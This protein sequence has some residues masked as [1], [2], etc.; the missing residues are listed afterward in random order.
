MNISNN[1]RVKDMSSTIIGI[2]ESDGAERKAF[3]EIQ[4]KRIAKLKA[5]VAKK[6][7]GKNI[8]KERTQIIAKLKAAGILDENGNI[9]ER[10]RIE[11]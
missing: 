4:E 11:D 2:I 5:I 9:A 7:N 1:K 3:I 8:N 10:Y 6:Q